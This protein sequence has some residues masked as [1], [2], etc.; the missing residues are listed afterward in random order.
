MHGN[1]YFRLFRKEV[2]SFVKENYG[3]DYLKQ[4][5]LTNELEKVNR[6]LKKLKKELSLLEKRKNKLL[7]AIKK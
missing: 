7:K 5:N 6:D 1:P 2:D 3:D 4:K